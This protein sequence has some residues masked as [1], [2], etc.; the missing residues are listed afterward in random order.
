[1]PVHSTGSR[2]SPVA[3]SILARYAPMWMQSSVSF[4]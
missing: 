3:A 1:M 4:R 2:I